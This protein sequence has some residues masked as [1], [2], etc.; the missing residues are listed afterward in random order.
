MSEKLDH[1]E[2]RH[3]GF[4]EQVESDMHPPP[5]ETAVHEDDTVADTGDYEKHR[6][7]I[8][9]GNP[10][11]LTRTMSA[12]VDVE[13]AQEEFAQLGRKLSGI[14]QHSRAL[15]RQQS[16]VSEKQRDASIREADV[17]KM[18]SP[19]GTS[20]DEPWDL[21]STLRGSQQADV[22]AGIKSKRIGVIWDKLS[23]RGGG[24]TKTI[25][26]TFPDAFVS[27]FNV[28][29][30]VMGLFGFG[31][32]TAEVNILSNFR[33]VAKPG[34]MVLVLGRPGSGCTTF[35]KVI[36][37]QRFGYTGIDGEI[38]YGRYDAKMFGKRY[39]A[40]AV[41]NQEDD[42]HHPTLTVGQTL[43]F[44]LDTKTPGKRPL[45]VSK[46]DF[47]EQVIGLLL[48]MFNIEHTR[49]TVVG[50]AFVRGISGGERKRVS[51]AEMMATGSCV[52]AWDNTTRGLDA[53]TALDYAKSLRIL[54]NIYK[55][56]TF[57]SLYQASENIYSQFDKVM[58]IDEGREVYFGP[59]REARAYFE[60]LGFK[61][62]PR[63]T[64]PD[65]LTGCTD[66]FERD[67]ADGQSSETVP[68]SPESLAQAFDKSETAARLTEEMAEYH[69]Q[70]EREQETHAE[71][72]AAQI[73]TKR[74]GTSKHSV[75]TIPYYTQIFVLMKRQYLIKWQDKFSLVV[76]WATSILVA[77]LLGTV[78]LD[79][80][81]DASGAFTRGGLL[82]ISLLFNAF[83]AFGELGKILF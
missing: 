37:N 51:V 54:T 79:L 46:Q 47:K 65:Y 59:A 12:G 57:V 58:V 53:S 21:E 32:K 56:T 52:T 68:S 83:Q 17:E 80:P 44:A 2:D 36:S 7:D 42:I 24:G 39:R 72:E 20:D 3:G 9:Q 50:N 16:R 10:N 48:R 76:S 70:I 45:G 27:L 25:V 28:Y 49:N 61:A 60:D 19:S 43:A 73:E 78:W 38:Q 11:G 71:F 18:G 77:I 55:T 34:E 74:K 75:Y 67:Y 63:Q 35:L 4:P 23:V 66:P 69:H 40:E 31:K 14:S 64:T 8:R 15:S 33:G 29:G 13:K 30:N 81:K 41:Y 62:K 26:P 22:E 6:E 1:P 5:P 82:F